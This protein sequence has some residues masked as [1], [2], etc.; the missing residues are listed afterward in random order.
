[1]PV[2]RAAVGDA[3]RAARIRRA[4]E[5]NAQVERLSRSFRALGDPTRSKMVYA[6]SVEELCVTELAEALGT[7]LSAISH[8]LRILRDLDIVRVRRDGKSQ[9]YALNEQAF[10][11]CSPRS[12]RAWKQIDG[13]PLVAIEHVPPVATARAR[14][15]RAP[16]SRRASRARSSGG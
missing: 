10:G 1:M 13:V 8:Q 3:A 9:V 14:N 16:S 11:F 7:S 12:C 4:L 15:R 2:A 6:L 5:D